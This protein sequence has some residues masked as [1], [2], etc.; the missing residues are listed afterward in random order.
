M[1]WYGITLVSEGVTDVGSLNT[2]AA[3]WHSTQ[4]GFLQN[5]LARCVPAHDLHFSDGVGAVLDVDLDLGLGIAGA[6]EAKAARAGALAKCYYGSHVVV[7]VVDA[8]NDAAVEHTRLEPI[9]RGLERGV[10]SGN[11]PGVIAIGAIAHNTIEAWV[12]A[13]ESALAVVAGPRLQGPPP[14][15]PE[16]LWGAPHDP[17]SNHPKQVL[18]RRLSGD[19]ARDDYAAVGEHLDPDVVAFKCPIGFEPL[20]TQ[21]RAACP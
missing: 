10:N 1:A 3:E 14:P 20:L 18:K 17:T 6:L 13:D 8:D 21:I 15:Y 7:F 2:P 4:D 16:R 12:L 11:G 5:T 9:Q 19:L